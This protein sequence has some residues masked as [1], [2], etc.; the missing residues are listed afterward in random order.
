MTYDSTPSTLPAPC[1]IDS[2][3]VVNKDD[4]RRLLNDL[5]HVHY[6]HLVDGEIKSAGEGWI[7]EVFADPHQAT[8]V[9]NHSLYLNLLSFDYLELQLGD[10]QQTIFDL[11]QDSR[12]LR[13]T[14]LASTLHDPEVNHNLDA[15]TL[16]D[17]VTQVLS[18]KW[19]MQF[20]EDE[21][22]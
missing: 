8:V 3:I 6:V 20:D 18:A 2:G 21:D 11:V 12:L 15:A 22:V 14:P 17:M 16:E 5:G 10:R 4:M 13:L 19:D 9:A 7:V 1:I